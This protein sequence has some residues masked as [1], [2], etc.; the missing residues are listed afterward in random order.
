MQEEFRVYRNDNSSVTFRKYQPIKDTE[1]KVPDTGDFYRIKH[2]WQTEICNYMPRQF[3]PEFEQPNLPMPAALM[4]WGCNKNGEFLT[5]DSS[6]Q[7]RLYELFRWAVGPIPEDGEPEFFYIQ[8]PK[9]HKNI[10][11]VPEG[12]MYSFPR[13]P[14]GTLRWA[15]MDFITDHRALTDRHAF[16]T[17]ERWYRDELLGINMWNSRNWMMKCLTFPGNI[18]KKVPR[19]STDVGAVTP[20]ETF[21]YCRTAPSLDWILKNK[22]YLIWWANEQSVVE[23]PPVNG[24]RRWVVARFPQLKVVCRKYG[25]PEVGTPYFAIGC[26]GRNLIENAWIEKINNGSNYSIYMPEK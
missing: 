16:D 24:K 6:W 8:D 19:L 10:I 11:K 3:D 17:P 20:I 7:T 1:L 26:G 13:Y 14:V 4:L 18:V 22:P 5:V 12:T 15:Y 25:I 9:N 23:L 21:D 2:D